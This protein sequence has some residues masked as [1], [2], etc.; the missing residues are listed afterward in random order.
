MTTYLSPNVRDQGL[1]YLVAHGSRLDI[2]SQAPLSYADI[3]TYSL[4][5]Y[6]SVSYTGPVTVSGDSRKVT[7]DAQAAGGSIT[8][9]GLASYYCISDGVSELLVVN[10]LNANVGVANPGTFSSTAIDITLPVEVSA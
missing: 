5:N 4:G 9:T 10:A 1:D 6:T 7:V 2:L 8:A 3:A